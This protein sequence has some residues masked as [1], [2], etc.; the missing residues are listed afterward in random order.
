MRLFFVISVALIGATLLWPCPSHAHGRLWDPPSRSTMFRRGF[1]VPANYDDNQLFCG[2][3]QHQ[4]SQGYRCGVCGDPWDGVRE[5]EAGGRYA[6]GQISRAYYQGGVINITVHLTANHKG[7]FEFKICPVNDPA[8]RATK[9]CLNSHN[10]TMEDGSGTRFGITT[11]MGNGMITTSW[12]LPSDVTCSQCVLQWR[13][14][15][16][17]SYGRNRDDG[18]ECVGCGYQEEFYGCADIQIFSPGLPLPTTILDEQDSNS[19]PIQGNSWNQE[20]TNSETQEWQQSGTNGAATNQDQTNAETQEW[21]QSGTIGAATN[22]ANES[23]A[24]RTGT[25]RTLTDTSGASSSAAAT[26]GGDN[27]VCQGVRSDLNE[28]CQLNCQLGFC[29]ESMCSCREGQY[30]HSNPVPA[31]CRAVGAFANLAGYHTW[32]RQNCALGNCPA[33]ICVC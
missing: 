30:V 14:H 2:G 25:G 18:R 32:C 1:N 17:N 19:L 23:A 9:E 15:A 27:I 5:N 6:T 22:Q 24:T 28:W 31:G 16:G 13:Y 20:Q 10:L 26:I 8:V 12:V 21:Q 3:L 7:F 11:E 33:S 4:I 29:P